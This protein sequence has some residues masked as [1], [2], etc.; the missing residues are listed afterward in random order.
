[1]DTSIRDS[2]QFYYRYHTLKLNPAQTLQVETWFGVS[3][4][5][6]NH[7]VSLTQHLTHADAVNV[8]WSVEEVSQEILLLMNKTDTRL[9]DH[10]TPTL[11]RSI[12][13]AWVSEWDDYRNA[14]IHRPVFKNSRD[15]QTLWLLDRR[16]L[17]YQEQSFSFPGSEVPIQLLANKIEVPKKVS[18]YLVSRTKQGNYIFVT[19]HERTCSEVH[20]KQD[21]EITRWGR[22]IVTIEQELRK[23]RRQYREPLHPKIRQAEDQIL[24]LRK[25]I[26]HRILRQREEKLNSTVVPFSKVSNF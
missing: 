3:R 24:I 25:I 15:E 5:I 18:A 14:R 10:L 13:S 17:D 2:L 11:V 9:F 19:L 1:M 7:L 6:S 26:L 21:G 8:H 20:Q 22:R 12:A 23:L 16:C 4:V